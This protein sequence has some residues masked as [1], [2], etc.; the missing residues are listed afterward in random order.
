MGGKGLKL[1]GS[2]KIVP[3]IKLLLRQY[4]H[5]KIVVNKKIDPSV[6]TWGHEEFSEHLSDG[7][8]NP[9]LPRLAI[10]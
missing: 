1:K 5:F 3:R 2:L 8:S 4:L 10:A 6:N 9:D 7:E